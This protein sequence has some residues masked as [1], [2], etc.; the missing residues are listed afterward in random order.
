MTEPTLDIAE[1]DVVI[2]CGGKGERLR[3]LTEA[4][5]KPMVEIKGK[6]IIAHILR[7]LDS[8][9]IKNVHLCTGYM[10]ESID[11]YVASFNC[12]LA[13]NT[14][15]AGDADIIER[16]KLAG[17]AVTG[18]F[19]VLYGDTISDVDLQLLKEFHRSHEFQST[20]TVWPVRSPFGLVNFDDSKKVTSFLEKPILDKF[21]NIGYFYFDQSTLTFMQDFNNWELFLAAIVE[22]D[23]LGA[24]EHTGLHITVNTSEELRLAEAEISKIAGINTE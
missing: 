5:P 3:P 10:H 24:F 21:M 2:L 16:I 23:M 22:K 12:D 4:C 13:I 19:L 18:D 20:M 9:G 15:Y 17:K 14:S 11:E 6:P 7:Y 1:L 8:Q